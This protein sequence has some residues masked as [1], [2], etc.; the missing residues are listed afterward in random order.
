MWSEL[1]ACKLTMTVLLV[2]QCL[3][4]VYIWEAIHETEFVLV[5]FAGISHLRSVGAVGLAFGT[6]PTRFQGGIGYYMMRE[7]EHTGGMAL[8]H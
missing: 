3:K 6:V 2:S 1:H 8:S 7:R 5:H 4:K